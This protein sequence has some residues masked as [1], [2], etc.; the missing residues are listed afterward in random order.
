VGDGRLK[1]REC[2]GPASSLEFW[3][4]NP[5]GIVLDSTRLCAWC[6]VERKKDTSS[7]GRGIR[8]TKNTRAARVAR[9]P[10]IPRGDE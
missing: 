6:Y 5:E 2:S 4:E 9:D 8:R 3:I 10:R 7:A 1:C